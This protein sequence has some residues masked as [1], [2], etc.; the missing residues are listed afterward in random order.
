L[1]LILALAVASCDG[2]NRGTNT[3]PSAAGGF[4]IVVTASPNVLRAGTGGLTGDCAIVQ[5]KVFDTHGQLVD[6][7]PVQ[8]TAGN[9]TPPTPATTTTIRGIA[10]TTF[11]AGT[12]PG[13]VTVTAAAEDAFGTTQIT[14][15]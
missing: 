13:T 14:V 5:A 6:G 12:R 10:Q 3:N 7:E 2:P 4:N 1:V 8:F 15:F 9:A 11:C